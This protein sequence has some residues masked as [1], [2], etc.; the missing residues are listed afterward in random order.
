MFSPFFT[1]AAQSPTRQ[2]TF[3]RVVVVHLLVLAAVV[4]G[5]YSQGREPA[6]TGRSLLGHLL[7]VAGIVEG[8]C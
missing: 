3:R 7:L 1:L 5:M 8:P 6:A 4:W 2:Q